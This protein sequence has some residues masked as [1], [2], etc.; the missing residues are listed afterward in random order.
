MPCHVEVSESERVAGY[1]ADFRHNSDVAA[2]L[3]KVLGKLEAQ[4]PSDYALLDAETKKWHGEHKRR[5]ARRRRMESDRKRE[6]R[7]AA[8]IAEAQRQAEANV[9][10]RHAKTKRVR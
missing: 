2:M 5:D 9:R 7:M 4:H 10:A 3:C 6:A 1:R 8:E